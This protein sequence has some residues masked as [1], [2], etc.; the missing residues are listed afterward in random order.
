MPK[1]NKTTSCKMDNVPNQ[2]E[3]STQ[4]NSCSEQEVDP[5]VSI[6]PPQAFPRMFM[7]YIEGHFSSLCYK[8]L[9]YEN[10]MS[11]ESRSPKAHQMRIGSVCAQDSICS[12]SEDFSSSDESFCLQMKIKSNEAETP[13]PQHLILNLA[14][15]LKPNQKKT[16]Y[17]RA[18][19]GTCTDGNILPVSMY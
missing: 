7:P 14:Y 17:L 11:L 16:Q 8:N 4:D 12:Q 15:K 3:G 13:A 19:I 1:P 2:D 5:E 6:N 18:R 10:K 9:G